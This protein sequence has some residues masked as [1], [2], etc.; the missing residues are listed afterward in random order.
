MH[1]VTHELLNALERENELNV[2]KKEQTGAI[3]GL[4]YF[5]SPKL[6]IRLYKPKVL[7]VNPKS[8]TLEMSKINT[9]LLGLLRRCDTMIM[10]KIDEQDKQEK[11]KY[12]IFYENEN[13]NTFC[14]RCYLPA[15]K[16]KYLIKYVVEGN[17]SIFKLPN[18]NCQLDEV[19]I[20][21]RNVWISNNKIG[22]NLELKYIH[23]Y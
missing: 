18:T 17:E 22:Y 2:V 21:I 10:G 3:V 5:I 14:L 1:I 12:N 20:D 9:G 15:Y 4:N 7:F 13:N 16:S 8:I 23:I 19:I 11:I 6:S